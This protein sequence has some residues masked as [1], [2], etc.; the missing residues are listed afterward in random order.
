MS[1]ATYEAVVPW[2]YNDPVN[3]CISPEL[4]YSWSTLFDNGTSITDKSFPKISYRGEAPSGIYALYLVI[5]VTDDDEQYLGRKTVTVWPT[6]DSS[7]QF[8]LE[9]L[10]YD[11][12]GSW[13]NRLTINRKNL[14]ENPYKYYLF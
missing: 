8:S 4:S 14:T 12:C 7:I 13:E 1:N 6:D 10:S 9:L 11:R 3:D 2:E 5:D